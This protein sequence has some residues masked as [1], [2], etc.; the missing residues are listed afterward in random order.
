MAYL[1]KGLILI[2]FFILSCGTGGF[3]KFWDRAHQVR[4]PSTS[5]LKAG[6]ATGT[7][8]VVGVPEGQVDSFQQAFGESGGLSGSLKILGTVKD[9]DGAPLT[10]FQM[11]FDEITPTIL[12]AWLSDGLIAYAEPDWK[13]KIHVDDR[14]YGRLALTYRQ[15]L[16]SAHWLNQINLSAAFDAID[17]GGVGLRSLSD[18]PIIAVLDSGVDIQHP[19]L[20]GRIFQNKGGDAGCQGSFFG[21]NATASQLD[22]FGDGQVWPVGTESFGQRCLS[23]DRS[24]ETICS[25]GTHVAGIIAA[26][27]QEGYGGI[28]PSCRILPIKVVDGSAGDFGAIYD[29]S[30]IAALNYVREL[31]GRGE[32][33]KIVNASFG[34]FRRSK[35]LGLLI[36]ELASGDQGVL[37]VAAAGNENT[38]KEPYPASLDEVLA[39]ANVDSQTM[40]RDTSS[41]FGS[42]VDLAAPGSGDCGA[43]SGIRSS[44][45]GGSD[46]CSRGTSFAAPVV[47]GVAGLLWASWPQ[48]TL[49]ELRTRLMATSN[50][51]LYEVKAN[52]AFGYNQQK[53]LGAGIIDAL[54]AVE[55]TVRIDVSQNQK[56]RQ[57]CGIVGLSMA[58]W[59]PL[60]FLFGPLLGCVM[61]RSRS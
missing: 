24:V 51:A 47:S 8:Y 41:N 10:A 49:T 57:G 60:L 4:H 14:D 19:A 22:S 59:S 29:S 52:E 33:I 12:D 36:K 40:I 53:M 18:G 28:C 2:Q 42:W 27:V 46:Q 32:P 16:S 35:T 50:P 30:L 48:M 39:V 11:E 43:G 6:M 54:A 37:F 61:L 21:C 31:R 13:S 9:E 25:H 38:A 26:K 55:G 3:E 23:P 7:S 56:I 58:G 5:D 20:S 17:A 15:E 34:K 45:P 1:T 44:V